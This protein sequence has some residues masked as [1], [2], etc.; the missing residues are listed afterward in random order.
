MGASL[1]ARRLVGGRCPG[2]DHLRWPPR[3]PC[4]RGRDR[5]DP[6]RGS[7]AAGGADRVHGRWREPAGDAA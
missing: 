3:S 6:A 5:P 1:F 4:P 7:R 2:G